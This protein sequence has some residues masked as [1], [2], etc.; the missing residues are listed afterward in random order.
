VTKES[1]PHGQ[2]CDEAVGALVAMSNR[3]IAAS[4]TSA[5]RL[6]TVR[7]QPSRGAWVSGSDSADA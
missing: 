2:G 7:K 5:L 4:L 3:V 1:K 6:L